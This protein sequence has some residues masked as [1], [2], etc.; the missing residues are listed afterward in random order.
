MNDSSGTHGVRLLVVGFGAAGRVY[1]EAFAKA[2]AKVTAVDPALNETAMEAAGR[3]GI[4]TSH[5]LPGTLY[6]VDLVV[7]L[8]PASVSLRIEAAIAERPGGCPV[9][10]LTSSTPEAMRAA[11]E[12]LGDRL[13]DGTVMGAVG[14]GG[15]ATPMILAGK[16]AEAVADILAA[17]GCRI[18]CLDG[19]PGD[20][21]TLKLLR[22]LFMKGLEA[23]VVETQLAA[24]AL[25]QSEN[26]PLALSDLSEVDINAFL[27]EML[28]THPKHAARRHVEIAAASDL[29]EKAGMRPIMADAASSLF[30]RTASFGAGPDET[31]GHAINWLL[32][33]TSPNCEE[34]HEQSPSHLDH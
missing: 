30:A 11:Q 28:R 24:A 32:K 34:R 15:V 23:L 14:L 10:D 1:C 7:V 9:L 4:D 26:L 13:V 33:T 18:T 8:T 29:M 31:P 3:L 2:G 5:T 12:L 22:S 20:A 27:A 25:D 16:K 21:S 17:L 19:A 6:D